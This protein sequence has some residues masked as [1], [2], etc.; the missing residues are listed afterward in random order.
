MSRLKQSSRKYQYYDIYLEG[1]SKIVFR[2]ENGSYMNESPLPPYLTVPP[3]VD[4]A[5][6]LF[7]NSE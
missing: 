7:T 5:L 1:R 3:P 6:E 4:A 2:F